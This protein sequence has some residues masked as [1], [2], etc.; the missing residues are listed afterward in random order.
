MATGYREVAIRKVVGVVLG[1]CKSM[2]IFTPP[3]FDKFLIDIAFMRG[4]DGYEHDK[5]E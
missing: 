2:Q 3:L 5:C 1:Y 4:L